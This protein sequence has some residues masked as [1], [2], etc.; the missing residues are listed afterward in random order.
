M[1]DKYKGKKVV[2]VIP[3]RM[4]SSRFYG[5]P[6]ARI[7]GKEMI[8]WVYEYCMKCR[9][10]KDVYVATDHE[11]VGKFCEQKGMRCIMTA[12][13]HK[14]CSERSD[15]VCRRVGAE[16]VVEIQGDEPTLRAQDVDDFIDR[17]FDFEQFDVVT[18]YV[19]ISEEEARDPQSVKIAVGNEGKALYFSRCA[20]PYNFKNR[21][22]E[23][24]KQVGLYVWP[25]EAIKRFSQ[26]P[27]GYLE[28]IEDT[29]MLRL[30]E[31]GFDV[32]LVSTDI[33]TV[34]VDLPQHIAQAEAFLTK[35]KEAG[36]E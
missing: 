9:N 3:A 15:E 22:P 34:G 16:Y 33:A 21:N 32:R 26:T 1:K 30:T 19:Q 8:Q 12:A 4:E 7:L 36:G 6:L 2:G 5:K 25:A 24:Y 29:H 10:L 20:I 17:A 35:R 31:Y 23:Y 11:D 18:Q 14:N 28:S 13:T 27:K